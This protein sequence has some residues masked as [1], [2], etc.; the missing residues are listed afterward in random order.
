LADK[1]FVGSSVADILNA[2]NQLRILKRLAVRLIAKTGK[3]LQD[4]R[5]QIANKTEAWNECSVD[6]LLCA[7]VH[8]DTYVLHCFNEVVQST[9]NAG[10][11]KILRKLCSLHGLVV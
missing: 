5:E 4:T 11:Q 10:I 3:R 2:E 1:H 8:C 7:R 9:T 6:L